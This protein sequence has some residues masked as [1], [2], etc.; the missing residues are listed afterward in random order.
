MELVREGEIVLSA[1]HE[2]PVGQALAALGSLLQDRCVTSAEVCQDHA[3]DVSRH[4]PV[5]PDGVVFP[6]NES[7]VVEIARICSQY[8]VPMIPYGTATGV[9]GGVIASHG[10]ISID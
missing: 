7:E 10:G 8:Q 3:I 4:A 6:Q 5:A 2:S 1:E 9:E